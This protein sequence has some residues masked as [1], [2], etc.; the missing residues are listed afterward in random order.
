M[1]NQTRKLQIIEQMNRHYSK[2]VHVCLV[3]STKDAS[4]RY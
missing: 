4:E 3:V 2:C 1:T